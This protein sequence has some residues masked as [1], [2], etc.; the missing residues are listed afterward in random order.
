MDSRTLMDSVRARLRLLALGAG[1][2][3]AGVPCAGTRT[4]TRSR[5]S[6]PQGRPEAG[7][8]TAV[9]GRRGRGRRSE[10]VR[11]WLARGPR[12][13]AGG[14][15]V[16]RVPPRQLQS[17]MASLGADAACTLYVPNKQTTVQSSVWGCKCCQRLCRT[18]RYSIHSAAHRV[19]CTCRPPTC[20][21]SSPPS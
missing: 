5:G 17:L 8:D 13:R 11:A 12:H 10:V 20:F 14:T 4:G 15:H 1:A 7:G 3:R 19:S 21:Q 6:F 2:E 18:G 9:S 16:Q